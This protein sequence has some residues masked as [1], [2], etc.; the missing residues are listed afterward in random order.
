M[1]TLAAVLSAAGLMLAHPAQATEGQW[2]IGAGPG[3]GTFAGVDS[4]TG[5]GFGVHGAYELSDMFNLQLELVA[6]RHAFVDDEAT[7]LYG[8]MAGMTYKL[9]VI[10]WVPYFGLMAGLFAFDGDVRPD[11]LAKTEPAI[12]VPLGMEYSFSRRLAVGVELRYQGFLSAP[13]SSLSDAPYFGLMTRVEYR[14]GW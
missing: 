4:G 3:L 8:A 5:F 13:M 12:I 9:D 7:G 11:P 1:R 2:H 14:L 6:S 10:E